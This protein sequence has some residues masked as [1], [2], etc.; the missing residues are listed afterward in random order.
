MIQQ[1]TCNSLEQKRILTAMNIIH[2]YKELND[3]GF[4][5]EGLRKYGVQVT[6]FSDS[7]IISYP[8][9]YDGGLFHVLIDLIH[10][11]I[12]LSNLGIFI[13]GGVSIGLAY[14]DK[15]NAFG[16]A[17]NDAYMLESKEAKFPRIILTSQ[18]LNS[19][20]A[21]SKN[22]QNHSDISLLKSIIKQDKDGF[23]YLD[24]LRQFQELDY[25]EYDYYIWLTRIRDHLINNLNLYY[26][27]TEIYHKYLWML[28]YWNDVFNS[29][30]LTIPLE[31]GTSDSRVKQIF[32]N[33]LS[34]AIKSD[35]PHL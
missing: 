32:E 12:D 17:M 13:R 28:D 16:P 30:N 1:S 27:D 33:Y 3:F 18:T 35:Y 7:A 9:S 10:L 2:S 29:S 8:I 22:H 31:E 11:Q 6:T 25:P 15:Y 19:G 24:Y 20:V 5:G 21:A 26:S 34:L 14:H 23:Y 4:D